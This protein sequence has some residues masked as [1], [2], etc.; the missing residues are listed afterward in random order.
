[1]HSRLNNRLLLPLFIKVGFENTEGCKL[2]RF[3]QKK[4]AYLIDWKKSRQFCTKRNTTMRRQRS[5]LALACMSFA[6]HVATTLAEGSEDTSSYLS[7]QSNPVNDTLIASEESGGH[8]LQ[9]DEHNHEVQIKKR[10]SMEPEAALD[11]GTNHNDEDARGSDD[12]KNETV[13]RIQ[14]VETNLIETRLEQ[15][16]PAEHTDDRAAHDVVDDSNDL[17][18][19]EILNESFGMQVAS[20]ISV[21]DEVD[22]SAEGAGNLRLPVGS[23]VD[24]QTGIDTDSVKESGK[25]SVDHV[26]VGSTVGLKV[27]GDENGAEAS[28]SSDDDF[29]SSSLEAE[30]FSS[31]NETGDG[32]DGKFASKT[33]SVEEKSDT[34][35]HEA[36]TA[37]YDMDHDHGTTFFQ[38]GMESDGWTQTLEVNGTT[39]TGKS[40]NILGPVESSASEDVFE[41]DSVVEEGSVIRDMF[42]IDDMPINE[43][44]SFL[45]KDRDSDSA[46]ETDDDGVSTFDSEEKVSSSIPP[47]AS[48]TIIAESVPTSMNAS[49]DESGEARA[50][51]DKGLEATSQIDDVAGES[52]TESIHVE[53]VAAI[54]ETGPD[55]TLASAYVDDSIIDFDAIDSDTVVP[56]LEAKE[57]SYSSVD[58][59]HNDTAVDKT[60]ER[61]SMEYDSERVLSEQATADNIQHDP[62]K[63]STPK[64]GS[65]AEFFNKV[66]KGGEQLS[67]S[68]PTSPV[69]AASNKN[70]TVNMI[71]RN[72]PVIEKTISLPEK[73]K[74]DSRLH[75]RAV[76]DDHTPKYTGS[77]GYRKHSTSANS[78]VPDDALRQLLG[79]IKEPGNSEGKDAPRAERHAF[80]DDLGWDAAETRVEEHSKNMASD[81]IP[82]DGGDV[83]E[84]GDENQSK[85]SAAEYVTDIKNE[86]KVQKSV[87]SEFVD[88]LDDIDKFLEAVDPPDELDV[89]AAG[90]SIQEVLIGQSAQILIK[91]VK[92]GVHFVSK[93]VR[94]KV[95]KAKTK[96]DEFVARRTDKDGDFALVTRQDVE[97]AAKKLMRIFTRV[98]KGIKELLD[99]ISGDEFDEDVLDLDF[100]L[101]KMQAKIDSLREK[102]VLPGP[103]NIAAMKEDV[104]AYA[105]TLSHQHLR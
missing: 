2:D 17:K 41:G 42:S 14:Q 103:G 98:L 72:E 19:Y 9:N 94:R 64:K 4:S 10:I 25:I 78:R 23:S 52:V 65:L 55:K 8:Y 82:D 96:I 105:D 69:T 35:R 50:A 39:S 100:D 68:A 79:Y 85:D 60:A 12:M 84:T 102:Q 43:T 6:C 67:T 58:R 54:N 80:S 45:N 11:S 77:W 59:N 33:E 1:M 88:G 40:S 28:R 13:L 53:G 92:L 83:A 93:F 38:G 32:I 46:V 3:F 24:Q 89:G 62:A 70:A 49:T 86:A 16:E 63:G 66:S 18:G 37:D 34:S 101:N 75:E 51:E 36:S 48:E 5:L 21:E 97:A 44:R 56:T 87:N 81:H 99:E 15:E 22:F 20:D 26:S 95:A 57:D 29:M 76:D 61:M 104:D 30:Q 73:E 31:G 71:A 47:E 90:S 7:N 27:D 91:R 74:K